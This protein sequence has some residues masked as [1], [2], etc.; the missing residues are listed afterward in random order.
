MPAARMH[1]NHIH[2]CVSCVMQPR[3][4]ANEQ[5]SCLLRCSVSYCCQLQQYA[6]LRSSSTTF[7]SNQAAFAL[8][9]APHHCH[10]CS[11]LYCNW[12]IQH[13][14]KRLSPTPPWQC[15]AVLIGRAKSERCQEP[16]SA[17]ERMSTCWVNAGTTIMNLTKKMH[18]SDGLQG[19]IQ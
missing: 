17:I 19:M 9:M 5:N 4:K 1:Q 15:S 8:C 16:Q 6:T 12:A 18:S 11:M 13:N 10:I 14:P 7:C 3:S 2:P